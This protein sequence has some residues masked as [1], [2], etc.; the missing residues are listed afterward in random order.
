MDAF[1]PDTIADDADASLAL[2]I[3]AARQ[4]E[5]SETL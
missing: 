4:A 1:V 5:C 3:L 2:R